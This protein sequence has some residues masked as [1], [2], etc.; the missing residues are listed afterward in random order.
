MSCQELFGLLDAYVD[1]E[2]D[3]VT[4]LQFERHLTEC[5]TCRAICQRYQQLHVSVQAQIPHFEA[6]EELQNKIRT[7]SVPPNAVG[8]RP[9]CETGLTTGAGG[10][11]QVLS[12]LWLS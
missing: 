4:I 9:F 11:S 7:R 1:R 8:M 12:Q 10:R 5:V 2:L 3:L 6:S